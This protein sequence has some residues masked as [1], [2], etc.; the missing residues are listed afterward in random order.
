MVKYLVDK[1]ANIHADYDYALRLASFYGHLKV[2]DYLT[3][4]ISS[5][6]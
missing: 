5:C 6:Q 2:V 1:G 4:R 3:E